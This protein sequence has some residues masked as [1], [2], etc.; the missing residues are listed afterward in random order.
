M[1][2]TG[3]RT[4][5]L[6]S[7]WSYCDYTFLQRAG[8]IPQPDV[9][10]AVAF[11]RAGDQTED[12]P[13]DLKAW[14]EHHEE[15]MADHFVP[16]YPT[17]ESAPLK[18]AACVDMQLNVGGQ[19]QEQSFE[20]EGEQP[21]RREL[22]A[23]EEP[24]DE[25]QHTATVRFGT[26]QAAEFA[27]VSASRRRRRALVPLPRGTCKE[28]Y[29]MSPSYHHPTGAVRLSAADIR[30]RRA[31]ARTAS[32]KDPDGKSSSSSESDSGEGSPSSEVG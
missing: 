22:D 5:E 15:R 28:L 13:S 6:L 32:G 27:T 11:T 10:L 19:L 31:A 26:P 7:A 1:G 2:G 21:V 8:A 25:P 12:H 17:A 20:F 29:S 18:L 9:P 24:A 3:I 23:A 30:N 14:V 16:L 4:G